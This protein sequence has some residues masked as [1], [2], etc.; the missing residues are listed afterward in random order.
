MAKTAHFTNV[1]KVRRSDA[2]G[3]PH[4]YYHQ[5][6]GARLPDAYGSPEFAVEWA[7][8]ER[9]AASARP[10]DATDPRSYRSLCDAFMGPKS[11]AW[12]KIGDHTRRDYLKCREWMANQGADLCP[13]DVLDQERCEK[14]LDRAVK[15][16]G[17]RRGIYVLQFNRRLY[18]WVLGRAS[19]KKTWGSVNPWAA[20]ELPDPPKRAPGAPKRNRPWKP[21]E[22]IEVLWEAPLGLR[23]A[24]VLGASG[25]DSSTA[26][27]MRWDEYEDGAIAVVRGK[28]DTGARIFVPDILRMFL[29]DGAK[30]SDFIATGVPGDKF[31]PRGLQKRSSEFLGEM[32]KAGKVGAG[33]TF[34]GLRHTMGKAIADAG[35]TV[36]AI[37]NA[38]QQKTAAM[39]LYYSNEADKTRQLENAMP[40][41]SEWFSVEKPKDTPWKIH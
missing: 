3:L 21:W 24:Y 11:D 37:Q 14:L 13:A 33:L 25:L 20:L 10:G 34:H 4:Y 38:L 32:A 22:V 30:P 1:K 23:R 15:D 39:A 16:L 2:T 36:P 19:R 5:H 40:G 12:A 26:S 29:E 8:Q 6:T 31:T 28:T 27:R 35:G 7:K 9:A 18:N 41:V 17:Y